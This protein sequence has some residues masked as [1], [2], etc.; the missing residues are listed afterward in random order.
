MSSA[1]QNL[2]PILLNPNY[3]Q[4][5]PAMTSYLMSQ[6]GQWR[7]IMTDKDRPLYYGPGLCAA[8]KQV[9]IPDNPLPLAKEED[10]TTTGK[11]KATASATAVAKDN[12]EEDNLDEIRKWDD[13]NNQAIGNIWLCLHYSIQH[14]Y[15][16]VSTAGEL[17]EKL[18]SKYNQSGIMTVYLNFKTVMDTPIPENADPSL[19]INKIT[20][21]FGKLWD[22]GVK[23][24]DNVQAMILM[25]KMPWYMDSVAQLLRQEDLAKINITALRK[26]II[27]AWEQRQGH[28]PRR[29][30]Q[31]QK[32][33]AVQ[34]G[35]NE[36]TFE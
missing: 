11:R 5:E 21:L 9:G 25:A 15:H 18:A 20:A 16:T 34:R 7:I 13:L 23:V 30:N 19:T 26:H 10:D 27:L 6:S 17:W 28:A 36:P 3:N 14:K 35:P 24:P 32:I 29:Q 4:W 8:R 12:D 33:S 22:N 2:I 1:L 31:A